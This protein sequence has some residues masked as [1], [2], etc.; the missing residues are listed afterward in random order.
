MEEDL[1]TGKHVSVI[2]LKTSTDTTDIRRA[3]EAKP[4]NVS[5]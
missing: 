4:N 1:V 2:K 5:N 3:K